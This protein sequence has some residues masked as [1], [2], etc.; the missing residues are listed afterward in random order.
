MSNSLVLEGQFVRLRRLQP[1]DAKTTFD[2]RSA[3]RAKYLNQGSSTVEDQIAWIASRPAS[4]I[5]FIIELSNKKA[6]GM[7][8]LVGIDKINRHAESGRFLIG[9]EEVAKGIPAAVEAMKLLYEF[10]FEELKLERIFG[11]VAQSNHLMIKWQKYL[12]MKQEG[13][14][15]RHYF[16][17]GEWQDA[18]CLGLLADEYRTQS[19]PRMNALIAAAHLN[20]T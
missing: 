20:R 3:Q 2:W 7:L 5:N 13:Q 1:T 8:S 19:L 15:R 17:D 4:E 10:A 12:G 6:I 14:L 16:I 11:T 18:I 9:E